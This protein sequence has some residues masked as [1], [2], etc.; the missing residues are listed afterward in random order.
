V[1][2]LK[3]DL[4]LQGVE[5][6]EPHFDGVTGQMR[7]GLVETVVQQ[8]SGIAAYQA[9]KAMKEKTAQIGRGRKLSDVF[10]IALPAEDRSSPEGAV[11]GTMID[12]FDPDP[13]T[14]V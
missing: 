3:P 2:S 5:G 14:L 8:E 13:E 12:A 10:D 4:D 7:R 1:F 11:F 9:I 6:I